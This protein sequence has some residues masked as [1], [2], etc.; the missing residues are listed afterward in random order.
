[1]TTEPEDLPILI[2]G[3]G[4][5]G[6]AAAL[7]LAQKGRAVHIVEQSDELN[8]VGAGIQLGPNVFRM[9][10]QLGVTEA[11]NDMAVFPDALVMM[12]ALSGEQ[13]TRIPLNTPEF[14]NHF[15]YPYGVIYRPDLHRVLIDACEAEHLVTLTLGQKILGYEDKNTG[16][17]IQLDSGESVSGAALIGADGLWSTIRQQMR[18]DGPPTVSGHIAYRAVLPTDEVPLTSRNNSVVLWA[19]PKTHLVHYPLQRGDIYNL[20][21][22]FHSERYEEGWDVYGDAE[23]L[24]RKFQNQHSAVHAM[25]DKIEAWRMWVLCD[26]E[27]VSDWSH[28]RVTLLGDAAHPMLQ[29][30]AQGACMA[31]E[32]AVCLANKVDQFGNDVES[33]FKA[34]AADRYLR[35]GRVQLTARLYGDV[36]HAK[37]VTA[38][39]RA[40]MLGPRAPEQAYQGMKWLYDGVDETGCQIL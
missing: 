10:D 24:A 7:A 30:L 15:Q 25:L 14:R 11:I 37:G 39:L 34:Y 23:E 12:D 3:G 6:F 20:V 1:M 2:A 31:T 17:E 19:G 38:E 26:R 16:V 18:Q 9:F 5:G 29:Y 8:E 27:P 40:L 4:I 36:Y 33:A 21:T 28:G 32:D 22:V 13:V 35:T